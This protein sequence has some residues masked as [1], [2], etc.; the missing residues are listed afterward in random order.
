M[1]I[2]FL[3]FEAGEGC[4]SL[5]EMETMFPDH[6][7]GINQPVSFPQQGLPDLGIM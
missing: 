3:E 5:I 7:V 4:T 1:C 2:D 6:D